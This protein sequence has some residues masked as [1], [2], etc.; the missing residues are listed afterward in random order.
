MV[1]NLTTTLCKIC[2]AT[3]YHHLDAT[4]L[5]KYSASLYCC[6][7][8]GF[9]QVSDPYWLEEAY[10]TPINQF[11]TGILMR[12]TRLVQQASSVIFKWFNRKG[13]FVDY[14]GGYGIFV[15]QMRDIGFD[16]YWDDLYAK[17]LIAQGFEYNKSIGEI[18]LVT[19]FENFEHFV[20]PLL[21]IEKILAVSRN[22]LFSTEILPDPIPSADDWWY[23]MFE[24]GQHISFYTIRALKEI[25]VKFGLNFYSYK[26]VH[27]FTD[28]KLSPLLFKF[29]VKYSSRFRH[30]YI[31]NK[32]KSKTYSDIEIMKSN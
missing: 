25:A 6:S 29:V 12:N 21:E 9:V 15:R 20:S 14:G 2:N 31:L 4:M 24:S 16:F 26:N 5:N 32:M 1:Y 10:V 19:S 3:A 27:L 17:N 18:E 22:V 8:C 28:K 13:Q 7:V 23:F 30:K 11:D